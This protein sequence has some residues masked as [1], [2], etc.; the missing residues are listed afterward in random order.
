[1]KAQSPDT[2]PESE[3]FLVSLLRK[4]STAEKFALVCSL[5]Q[6][7]IKLSKR[8]IARANKNFNEDDVNIKFVELH[9]GKDLALRFQKYI[10]Q[11]RNKSDN[12]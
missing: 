11:K 10:T 8:A 5:S 7:T 12:T 4:K 9:Y 1:M 2:H 6:S 3:A